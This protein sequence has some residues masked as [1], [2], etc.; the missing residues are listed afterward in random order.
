MESDHIKTSIHRFFDDGESARY[1]ETLR[2]REH[3]SPE[4]DLM[5]AVLKDGLINY[6]RNLQDPTR[7][8]LDDREWFFGA[9]NDDLFSF[10][11]ICTALGLSAQ[12]I[13]KRL[14]AWEKE[15]QKR[16]RAK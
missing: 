11:S 2:R 16:L 12:R 4:Q 9:H 3:N 7:S 8:N 13:R 15:G 1:W 14:A 6:R 10:E 5:L